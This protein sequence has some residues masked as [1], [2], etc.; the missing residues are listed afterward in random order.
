MSEEGKSGKILFVLIIAAAVA[1]FVGLRKYSEFQKD[2]YLK[3]AQARSDLLKIMSALITYKKEL[4]SYPD[5][6]SYRYFLE[7]QPDQD[8]SQ[9]VPKK[10]PWGTEYI[11]IAPGTE[12]LPYR[13]TS[14]GADK[15]A[16]GIGKDADITSDKMLHK[17]LEEVKKSRE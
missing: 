14:Y 5:T 13:I 16:G 12:G 1:G 17:H 9:S 7:F 3:P 10:D 15:T 11:Y 2:H 6:K 8:Y 4:G